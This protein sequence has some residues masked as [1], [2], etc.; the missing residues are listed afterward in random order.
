M[1]A[2]LQT[3]QGYKEAIKRATVWPPFE[4]RSPSNGRETARSLCGLFAA[5]YQVASFM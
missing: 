4:G 2:A 3:L 1:T 5:P